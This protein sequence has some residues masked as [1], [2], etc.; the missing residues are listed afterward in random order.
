MHA[1]EVRRE[2]DGERMRER[3][4]RKRRGLMTRE[5]GLGGGEQGQG[6]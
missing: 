1:R 5:K 6:V 2:K 4:R 3:E